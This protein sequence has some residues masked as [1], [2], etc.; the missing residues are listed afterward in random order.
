MGKVIERGK[1]RRAK[2][3]TR[4]K[5]QEQAYGGG[6]RTSAKIRKRNESGISNAEDLQDQGIEQLRDTASARED[7]AAVNNEALHGDKLDYAAQQTR[8]EQ[9]A[10]G[11]RGEAMEQSRGYGAGSDQSLADYRTGRGA[12]L[13]GA[14]KLENND[15][16]DNYSQGR[17]AI[18]GGADTLQREGAASAGRLEAAGGSSANEL[19][20]YARGA[21][22][23][24][25]SAADA[26]FQ[27][28]QSRNQKNALG[29]AAGRAPNSIRTALATSAAGNQ[30]AA[31][32]QQ[33]VKAQEANQLN[34]MRNEAIAQASGIRT[35][36]ISDAAG[37]NQGALTGAAGIRTNLSAQDQAA[38]AQ[39]AANT[40]QAAQIR[41]Q[42]GQQDQSAAQLEA[43][44]QQAAQGAAGSLLGFQGDTRKSIGASDLAFTNAAQNE[45][46]S[47]AQA[48]ATSGAAVTNAGGDRTNTY[49][50]ADTAM[51]T[52]GLGAALQTEAQRQQYAKD[53]SA[54]AKFQKGVGIATL[55][56]LGS[57]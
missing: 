51:N 14:D 28:A 50:G 42:L 35:G 31:L 46:N 25:Q 9:Q 23:E 34:A 44:R 47:V 29:L 43:Q 56:I 27:A 54:S 12:V 49:V 19:E 6:V 36:A 1:K 7:A 2:Q 18:L 21:A 4:E 41:T 20:G 57:K 11:L 55:G 3:S 10:E 5:P 32:D 24:Y 40:A 33:V 16:L 37:I 26:A 39:Q 17:G 45:A 15:W 8:L 22:G 13:G 52:A 30:Q 38:A 48:G 53:T